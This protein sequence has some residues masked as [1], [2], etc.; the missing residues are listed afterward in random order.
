MFEEG[1]SIN[2][3]NSNKSQAR[4]VNPKPAIISEEEVE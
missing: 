2:I 1:Y 3:Y 4:T